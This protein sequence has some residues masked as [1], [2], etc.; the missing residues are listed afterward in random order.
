MSKLC[1]FLYCFVESLAYMAVSLLIAWL[2]TFVHPY[3]AIPAVVV[4]ICFCMLASLGTYLL[5]T[6]TRK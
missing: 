2:A 5:R 6:D 3:G 4:V 1:V